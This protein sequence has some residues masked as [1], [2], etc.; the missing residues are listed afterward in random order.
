MNRKIRQGVNWVE[1]FQAENM[2]TGALGQC[3]SRPELAQ[4][5]PCPWRYSA[6][7]RVLHLC[8]FP[9]SCFLLI[10]YIAFHCILSL[11]CVCLSSIIRDKALDPVLH[12]VFSIWYSVLKSRMGLEHRLDGMSKKQKVVNGSEISEFFQV[13]FFDPS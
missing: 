8:W 5:T 11:L 4:V 2:Q 13:R 6:F 9:S 1:V 10:C 3:V 7:L 12:H